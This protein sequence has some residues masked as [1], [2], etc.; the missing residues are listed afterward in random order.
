MYAGAIFFREVFEWSLYP[1][2]LLI[3]TFTATFSALGN[4][5]AIYK[6]QLII[7]HQLNGPFQHQPFYKQL[8]IEFQVV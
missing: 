8:H 6:K 3:L 2:V 5:N 7:N 1:S 4:V